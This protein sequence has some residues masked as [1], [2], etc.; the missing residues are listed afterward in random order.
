MTH[1]DRLDAPVGQNVNTTFGALKTDI[2][3]DEKLAPISKITD[4][5]KSTKPTKS[6]L[7]SFAPKRFKRKSAPERRSNNGKLLN[8]G[9]KNFAVKFDKTDTITL[10]RAV[11]ISKAFNISSID[12]DAI[13]ELLTM[14]LLIP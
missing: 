4:S 9:V 13:S 12:Y 2:K 11:C 6:E 10:F 3:Q 7:S 8:R 5:S 1:E 14:S